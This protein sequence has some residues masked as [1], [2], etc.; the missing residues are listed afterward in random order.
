MIVDNAPRLALTKNEKKVPWDDGWHTV[1]LVRDSKLGTT[2]VYFDDMET[3]H[4]TM[5]DRTSPKE[6]L[7]LDH[8]MT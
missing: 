6:E 1:K 5:T 4:M 3:P 7:A 8:S 2:E